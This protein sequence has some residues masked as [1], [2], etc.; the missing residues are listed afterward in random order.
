M[1]IEAYGGRGTVVLA[2]LLSTVFV[3]CSSGSRI[4]SPADVD[5]VEWEACDEF[6]DD[7]AVECGSVTV[8]LD[9]RHP[10]EQTI[11][12]ALIRYP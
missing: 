11:D 9:Y 1:L 3:A 2:V 8:P 5:P 12:I 6:P 4:V 7:D 10:D